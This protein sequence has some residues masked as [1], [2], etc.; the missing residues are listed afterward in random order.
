MLAL[1]HGV[2]EESFPAAR[3]VCSAGTIPG[4]WVFC[5]YFFC[6]FF[7]LHQF[8]KDMGWVKIE[9]AKEKWVDISIKYLAKTEKLPFGKFRLG[10]GKLSK[11]VK[12]AVIWRQKRAKFSESQ[13]WRWFAM[14]RRRQQKTRPLFS[15]IWSP[16]IQPKIND[17]AMII[18]IIFLLT[19]SVL[20][21]NEGGVGK[22]IPNDWEISRDPRDV[23]TVKPERH[24]EVFL[25][26]CQ[27]LPSFGGIRTFY[28]HQCYP[29]E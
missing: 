16:D 8:T 9:K 27:Y 20:H 23:P 15:D 19:V 29:W 11:M 22:S 10:K 6:L 4:L 26:I 12:T 28:H 5:L 24:F 21:R 1:I 2:K 7:H 14:N 25:G 3:D 13:T 17:H 18:H